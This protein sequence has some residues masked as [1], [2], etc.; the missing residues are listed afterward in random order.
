MDIAAAAAHSILRSNHGPSNEN[1]CWLSQSGN[2]ELGRLK[3]PN[4]LPSVVGCLFDS[5]GAFLI[6]VT[7]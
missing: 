5:R 6:T 3:S 2:K 1:D 4:Y 7:H